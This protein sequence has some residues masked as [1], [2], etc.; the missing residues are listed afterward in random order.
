MIY[1]ADLNYI[2]IML[3]FDVG[4]GWVTSDYISRGLGWICEVMGW[5]GLQKM[6]PR[7]CLAYSEEGNWRQT[8]VINVWITNLIGALNQEKNEITH[9]VS[10]IPGYATGIWIDMWFVIKRRL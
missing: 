7:P 4:L 1:V 8:V 9:P 6:D 2:Y 3:L 10:Q 5:V